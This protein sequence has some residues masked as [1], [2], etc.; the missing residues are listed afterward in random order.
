[1]FTL[2]N[3]SLYSYVF[4]EKRWEAMNEKKNY[5]W[6]T[7]ISVFF[8]VVLMISNIVSTKILDLWWFTFDWW[9]LLF[10]LSYIFGDILT[11]V[12]GYKQS[13]KI[14]WM[15]FG[16]LVLMA[17]TIIIVGRLP[18]AQGRNYQQEYQ[19]I[20]GLTPRIVVASL[21]AYFV[22]EFSNSYI[23]AK[24]KIWMQGKKL[25]LRT[26]WSTLVGEFLDT[27]IFVLIAFYGVVNA[28]MMVPLLVSNYLFKVGV[29]V[30]FTPITYIIVNALKKS[31]HEDYYDYA[32]DFNPLKIL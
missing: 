32:T 31:E 17:G 21:L 28:D 18:A 29:E 14:I 26:I 7:M 22:G 11:E 24:L 15:G 3:K 30:M 20:L 4:Y 12:Y 1:M 23:L 25:W 5:K 9:T 13:R 6:I 2:H 19:H 16:A 27:G 8:V 10:P